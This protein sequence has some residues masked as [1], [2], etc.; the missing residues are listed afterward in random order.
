M[1]ISLIESLIEYTNFPKDQSMAT[2]SMGDFQYMAFEHKND[3]TV[4]RWKQ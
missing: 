1:E 4:K 2:L 3:E